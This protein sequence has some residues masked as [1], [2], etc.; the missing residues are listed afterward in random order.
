MEIGHHRRPSSRIVLLWITLLILGTS[1]CQTGGFGSEAARPVLNPPILPVNATDNAV[2][3]ATSTPGTAT[4]RPIRVLKDLGPTV[5]Y[6]NEDVGFSI[7]YPQGWSLLDVD[8]AIRQESTSYA[9]TFHSWSEHYSLGTE[10]IPEGGTKFDLVVTR[11]GAKDLAEAAEFL[12]LEYARADPAV[13]ILGTERLEDCQPSAGRS[14]RLTA[15][16]LR[17][18]S[19]HFMV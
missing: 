13:K 12:R 2:G 5:T 10:G 19:L 7:E 18:I 4:S 11:S 17:S 6:R 8:P 14:N 1:G 3:L 15:A 9:A 16:D